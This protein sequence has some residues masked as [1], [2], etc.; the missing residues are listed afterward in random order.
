MRDPDAAASAEVAVAVADQWQGLG[1]GTALARRLAS[2]ATAAGT[3]DVQALIAAD[4]RASLAL[5][6]AAATTAVGPIFVPA[7]TS[8]SGTPVRSQ[9]SCPPVA[10]CYA[11]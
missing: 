3:V 11:G 4:N 1:V 6:R 9:G 10:R 7:V 2:E 5:V 8:F